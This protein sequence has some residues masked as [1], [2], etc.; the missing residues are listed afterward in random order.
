MSTLPTR[1]NWFETFFQGITLD[2]WRTFAT[3]ELTRMEADFLE[4]VFPKGARLL[5][6]PCGNGRLTLELAR[7]GFDT[8]GIDI[9]NEFI[10][11]ATQEAQK[12]GVKT[13]FE[14]GD[15]RALKSTEE[16]D[17]AL[18]WGNSFGYFEYPDM[19]K[20]VAGVARAL[21]T[22]GRLVVQGGI[23]AEAVIPQIKER[24]T[25]QVNDITFTIENRYLAA[26][27]CLETKGTFTRDGKEEVRM[28]WHHI[29]TLAEIRRMLA[30]HGLNTLDTFSSMDRAPFALGSEQLIL[31]AQKL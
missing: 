20:F 7:R 26:E 18:C 15:M 13:A 4:S 21:K 8:T 25:Y 31:L 16:F 30:S 5:D 9:A 29:Y 24:E 28:F 14:V 22:G 1:T 11:E 2:L 12:A 6:A 19:M 10:H 27:S 23:A 17:G 3:P